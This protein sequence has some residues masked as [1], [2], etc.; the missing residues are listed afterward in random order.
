MIGAPRMETKTSPG[1]EKSFLT[2]SKPNIESRTSNK[3][4]RSANEPLRTLDLV[5]CSALRLEILLQRDLRS[6]I[7][8]SKH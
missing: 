3:L 8:Y 4:A 7:A 1:C 6:R 5:C 2:P